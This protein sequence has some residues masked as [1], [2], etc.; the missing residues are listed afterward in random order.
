M[1][2]GEDL[3]GQNNLQVRK[4]WEKSK[5]TLLKMK[6]KSSE[7]SGRSVLETIGSPENHFLGAERVVFWQL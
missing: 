4:L 7:Q 2:N 6:V 5:T 3:W 1:K